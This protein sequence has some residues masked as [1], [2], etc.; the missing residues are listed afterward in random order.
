[1]GMFFG[2]RPTDAAT[3][4][5]IE[6]LITECVE[7]AIQTNNTLNISIVQ[8]C[9]R[10]KERSVC[11]DIVSCLMYKMQCTNY[12]IKSDMTAKAFQQREFSNL[13]IVVNLPIHEGM[14]IDVTSVGNLPQLSTKWHFTFAFSKVTITTKT[15]TTQ[16]RRH[17]SK[18]G[19]AQLLHMQ[20]PQT[21]THVGKVLQASW[22]GYSGSFTPHS[23]R[24]NMTR[25]LW[26]INY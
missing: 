5:A 14:K 1:M 19:V 9:T 12:T 4:I 22:K 3:E 11:T 20:P 16:R 15:T 18:V 6:I 21:L 24:S 25:N 10:F 26:S 7:F 23:R 8:K 2:D 17:T 13:P